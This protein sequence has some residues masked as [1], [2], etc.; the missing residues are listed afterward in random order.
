MSCM[1]WLVMIL[2][3]IWRR[4]TEFIFIN[5]IMVKMQSCNFP[6][7]S[8][9]YHRLNKTKYAT[10]MSNEE[11]NLTVNHITCYKYFFKP[12]YGRWKIIYFQKSKVLNFHTQF[13]TLY[14]KPSRPSNSTTLLEVWGSKS[15]ST[16]SL[17]SV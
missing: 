3:T 16:P 6:P 5:F 8:H 7:I 10:D 11:T 2:W 1:Q 4:P 14:M 17:R 13:P 9:V 15:T 12:P